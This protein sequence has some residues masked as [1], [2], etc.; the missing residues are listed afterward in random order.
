MVRQPRRFSVLNSFH[1]S[2]RVGSI[3]YLSSELFSYTRPYHKEQP[4]LYDTDF[5]HVTSRLDPN[6]SK[7]TQREIVRV[8]FVF[9]PSLTYF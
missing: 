2:K 9:L 3:R 1:E 4:L 7:K 5:P 6:D 8:T